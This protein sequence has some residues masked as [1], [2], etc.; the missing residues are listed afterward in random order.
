MFRL[1]VSRFRI[2]LSTA[3]AVAFLFLAEPTPATLL[4]GLPLVILG[5]GIRT[6]SSG[7]IR[8]NKELAVTGPYAYT[9]N[10]LYL[11][12]F[13]IGLGFV[14]MLNRPVLVAVFLVVF[15]L[16][17]R[18]LIRE[19]EAVLSGKFGGAYEDYLKKVPRFFPRAGGT[20]ESGDFSWGLV[21]RHQ[22]YYAWLGMAGGLGWLLWKLQ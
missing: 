16:V 13:L 2:P 20:S 10:P 12:N 11:G 14:I 8:K 15:G 7:Y 17:Y 19:E 21:I 22:E 3:I 5:G 6:W 9:R 1:K 18:A 4:A